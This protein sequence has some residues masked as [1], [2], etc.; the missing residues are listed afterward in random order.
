MATVESEAAFASRASNIGL[1]AAIITALKTRGIA[2]FGRFAFSSSY[3][4]GSNDET[5]FKEMVAE[6]LGRNP[7]TG[8]LALLRRLYF[9][10]HALSISDLRSRVENRDDELPKKLPA[11]ERVA[12][13][14]LQRR[15]LVAGMEPLTS[16]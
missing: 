14:N 2:T 12:R 9:E 11:P 15:T 4:P 8:E 5:P 1:S 16:R 10:S 6:T 3:Q 7:D 13:L